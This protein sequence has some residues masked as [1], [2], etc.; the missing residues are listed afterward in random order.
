MTDAGRSRGSAPDRSAP[1]HTGDGAGIVPHRA[2]VTRRS[3]LRRGAAATAG[4]AAVVAALKPLTDPA[5]DAGDLASIEQF[6]QRR[7][8]DIFAEAVSHL[9]AAIRS[10]PASGND[11]V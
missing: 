11:R 7:P 2:G 3:F 1:A 10:S 9:E 8:I 6:L 5:F 4:I